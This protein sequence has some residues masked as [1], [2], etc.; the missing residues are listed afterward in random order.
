M[1]NV[2]QALALV[3]QLELAN[4]FGQCSPQARAVAREDCRLAYA[5]V[6]TDDNLDQ[7]VA[8]HLLWR[9]ETVEIRLAHHDN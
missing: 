2:Y 4:R 9:I 3:S 8:Q 6:N 1:K 5:A 7:I